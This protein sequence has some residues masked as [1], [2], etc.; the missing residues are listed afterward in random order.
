MQANSRHFVV[1][2]LAFLLTVVLPVWLAI[3]GVFDMGNHPQPPPDPHAILATSRMVDLGHTITQDM[4]ILPGLP[5]PRFERSPET[6]T[7]TR[8]HMDMQTGTSMRI[9]SHTSPPSPTLTVDHLS[10]RDLVLPVVVLDMRQHGLMEKPQG[11]LPYQLTTE[12]IVA[13]EEQHGN[14]PPG[15]MVL[16]TT[17]WDM[18]WGMPADYLNLDDHQQPRVPGY[19][20]DALALLVQERKVRGLGVDSPVLTTAPLPIPPYPDPLLLLVNLTRLEQ[21]PPTG[22]TVVIGA[23]RVQQSRAAPARVIALVP[24]DD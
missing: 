6:G 13:W 21:L 10:P 15:C 22:A 9:H 11:M 1:G 24:E 2:L 12:A 18:R 7:T 3:T 17:G 14:I 8:L 5:A 20:T 4:P 19:T 16:L 23:L